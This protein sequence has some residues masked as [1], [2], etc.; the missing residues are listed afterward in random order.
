MDI[1]VRE[2]RAGLAG[3]VRRAAA[4]ES[5]VITQSGRPVAV[6]G[7]IGGDREAGLAELIA[8]GA[9]VAPRVRASS[10]P[11]ERE[12][13]PVDARSDVELRKVR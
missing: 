2:L 9:V 7:C 10:T 4:G 8:H 13:L 5:I 3:F 11:V 1:G 6:L 12:R